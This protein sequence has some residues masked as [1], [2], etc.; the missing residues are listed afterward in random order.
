MDAD[1]CATANIMDFETFSK[2]QQRSTEDIQLQ[3]ANTNLYAYAQEEPIPLAGCFSAHIQNINNEME[4]KAEF[5]VVKVKTKSRPLIRLDTSVKLGVLH[6]TNEIQSAPR[7]AFS[8]KSTPLLEKYKN[9]FTG[10][11]LHKP[12]KAT[13]IV[14]ESIPPAALKQRKIPYHLE[15]KAQEEENRFFVTSE[16]SKT[17]QVT[18]LRHVAQTQWLYQNHTIQPQ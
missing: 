4:L 5:L 15:K 17:C 11:G 8:R 2:I 9:V 18:R 6:L 12:I 1:S 13:L 14:D 10:L 3:P 16:L 7:S